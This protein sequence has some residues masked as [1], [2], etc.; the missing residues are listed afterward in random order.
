MKVFASSVFAKPDPVRPPADFRH[1]LM[2]SAI[3]EL[4]MLSRR[5]EPQRDYVLSSWG[6]QLF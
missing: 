5:T 3:T 1:S 6:S 2:P 4:D